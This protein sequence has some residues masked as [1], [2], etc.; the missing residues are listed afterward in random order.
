MNLRMTVTALIA[1]LLAHTTS[2]WG[3]HH[4]RA[5]ERL[6]RGGGIQIIT[7]DYG[8]DR[9]ACDA[10]YALDHCQGRGYCEIRATNALCGDPDRGTR[11]DLYLRYS[12]GGYGA[13]SVQIREGQALTISCAGRDRPG[14]HR[15]IEILRADYGAG[16]RYCDAGFAFA[17]RCNGQFN[18]RVPVDNYL[19]GDPYRGKR[20]HVE[21]EYRCNGRVYR[22]RAREETAA[23]L[24]CR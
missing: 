16:N 7:A 17:E 18:C 4:R 3:D 1:V 15:G 23:F 9:R 6:Q 12:C 21:V 19:C 8:S 10:T 13:E 24:E 5:T 2:A 20:K 22:E 14:R 11:K